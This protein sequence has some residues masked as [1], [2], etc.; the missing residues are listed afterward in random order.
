MTNP[1]KKTIAMVGALA[2]ASGT[3]AACGG[4]DTVS[5]DEY[6]GSLCSAAG[7]FTTTVVEGQSALQEAAAGDISAEE[8]KE[9]LS[10][11]FEDATSAG[12]TAATE[13]EDAGV[14]DVENGEEIAEALSTAF[15]EVATA[16]SDAQEDV[17]AL[18]TDSDEAFQSGAEEL[19]TTFQDDV[20]SIGEGL[21][22][23]GESSELETAAE[24]NSECQ[25]LETGIGAPTGTTGTS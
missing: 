11:F 8:G 7:E 25:A 19:A 18:P 9:Q 22:S 12:E 6:V 10:S 14:P 4:D 3:I 23:L 16:L 20:S 17:D 1:R 2:L 24:E 21:S 15:G 5:A 13:I